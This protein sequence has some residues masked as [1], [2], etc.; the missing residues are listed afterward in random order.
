MIVV[1]DCSLGLNKDIMPEKLAPGM[2]SDA[3]NMRFARGFAEK[4]GGIYSQHTASVT[5]YGVFFYETPTA[6]YWVYTGLAHVYAWSSGAATQITPGGGASTF[7]GAINDRWTG[8]VLGGILC[9]NN[10]V[11]TPKYWNGDTGTD[12]ATLTGWDANWR[13][14]SLRPWKQFLVAINMTE[15]STNYAHKVRLSDAAT[16]GSVPGTWDTTD[17]TALATAFELGETSDPLV[18]GMPLGD[19]FIFYGERSMYRATLVNGEEVVQTQRIPTEYGMIGRGCGAVTPLG[20]VVLAEG[21][22]ILFDGQVPRSIIDGQLRNWLFTTLDTTN[23]RRAFVVANPIRSEVLIAFPSRGATTCDTALVWNWEEKKWGIRT[24][25]NVTFGA[26]GLISDTATIPTWDTWS[27]TTWDQLTYPWYSETLTNHQYRLMLCNTTALCAFD[28]GGSD[29]GTAMTSY[30]ERRGLGY[31]TDVK[32][33]KSATLEIDAPAGTTFTVYL[34]STMA[35]GEAPVYQRGQ[36][37][38]VGTTTRVYSM[39]KGR[40]AAI[41]IS[42]TGTALWRLRGYVIEGQSAGKY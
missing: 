37:Y 2:W 39:C 35:P 5:P 33:I 28:Y 41:K 32:F 42:H 19:N 38:T 4:I 11:D 13:C 24:L 3:Q 21:D 29:L 27:A 34:G 18:D 40:A 22:V 15:S 36:T 17:A 6:N 14:K 30:V 7:T 9:L 25:S 10:A 23:F 8:G 12:L 31:S 26:S 1:E 16:F 20:H